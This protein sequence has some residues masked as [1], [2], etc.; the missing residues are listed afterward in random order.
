MNSISIIIPVYNEAKTISKLI[1]H[2]KTQAITTIIKEIIVVDGGSTDNT[3]DIALHEGVIVLSS[4][5]VEL[6]QLSKA[7]RIEFMDRKIASSL[8]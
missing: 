5:D 1:W 7:I 3:K 2:L 6:P 8:Y 4:A